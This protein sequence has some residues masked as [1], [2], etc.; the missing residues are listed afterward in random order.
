[1]EGRHV[2]PGLVM[3]RCHPQTPPAPAAP[4]LLLLGLLPYVLLRVGGN[5]P[6]PEEE[7][8]AP[9]KSIRWEGCFSSF[10]TCSLTGWQLTG[11]TR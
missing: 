2:S 3:G 6:A 5:P 11:A 7:P 9:S 10:L 8:L 4:F 1:M